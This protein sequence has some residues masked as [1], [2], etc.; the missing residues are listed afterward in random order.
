MNAKLYSFILE[1]NSIEGIIRPLTPHETE[2]HDM[3]LQ[4]EH[5]FLGDIV[6]FV[7][8]ICGAPLREHPGLDVRVGSH[9]AIPGGYEVRERLDVL[10]AQINTLSLSPYEA[11]QRYETLHPFLDGNGRSGR[12]IW[13]WHMLKNDEDPFALTFLHRW[14]YDS[15]QAYR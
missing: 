1:S 5:L 6:N 3:L 7:K 8:M 11:H 13:C 4:L 9:I 14:Y 15:L 2:A 10:L 12:A